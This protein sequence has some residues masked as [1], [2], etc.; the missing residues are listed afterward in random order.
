MTPGTS[1]P[2]ALGA[3]PLL[4]A[5]C[6]CGPGS[7]DAS[8]TSLDDSGSGE[9]SP[10]TDA[11]S[12]SD[13]SSTSADDDVCIAYCDVLA[14]CDDSD[15]AECVDECQTFRR[16]REEN[17][18]AG[19]QAATEASRSCIAMSTCEQLDDFACDPTLLEELE[20]CTASPLPQPGLQSFCTLVSG[21]TRTS[22]DECIISF[23]EYN[24]LE[25]YQLDCVEEYEAL[26][27]CF[28]GLTCEQYDDE[29]MTESICAAEIA[30]LDAAC[31]TFGQE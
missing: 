18:D 20:V 4:V 19:C 23:L 10:Q 9:T 7:D 28:G 29:A 30:G 13:E 31:P 11:G 12:S 21:C 26:M 2:R 24:I 1:I 3:I 17:F 25:S 6:A 14:E 16:F 15:P 5:L 8:S 22:Y 27:T